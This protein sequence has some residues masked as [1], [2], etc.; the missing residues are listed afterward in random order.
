MIIEIMIETDGAAFDDG[1][2]PELA[3]ILLELTT[4]LVAGTIRLERP[5]VELVCMAGEVFGDGKV[6]LDSNGNVCGRLKV[7]D[8]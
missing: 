2:A 3:C 5:P 6:I 1:V 7:L 8:S 4:K